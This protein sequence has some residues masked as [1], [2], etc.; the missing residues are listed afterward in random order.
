M[1]GLRRYLDQLYHGATPQA[2]MQTALPGLVNNIK[3]M[4]SISRFYS[5]SGFLGL[6]FTKITNQLVLACKEY[7]QQVTINDEGVDNLWSIVSEEIG[8]GTDSLSAASDT[9]YKQMKTHLENKL[10]G[11]TTQHGHNRDQAPVLVEETTLF[12]RMKACLALL[13][14]Y[15]ECVHNVRDSLGVG[16][17]TMSHYPSMSSVAADSPVKGTVGADGRKVISRTAG[18]YSPSKKSSS[19]TGDS[20]GVTMSDDDAIIGHFE[21]FSARLKQIMD[22]MNTMS[23]Y[24]KLVV[25]SNGI[26]RPRPED[27]EE[28]ETDEIDYRKL[29]AQKN[30]AAEKQQPVQPIPSYQPGGGLNAIQEDMELEEQETQNKKD[31]EKETSQKY[32][33]LPLQFFTEPKALSEEDVEILRMFALMSICYLLNM[34]YCFPEEDVHCRMQYLLSVCYLIC[35]ESSNGSNDRSV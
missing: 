20:H 23:Q 24:Q 34:F 18:G 25:T 35:L 30:K 22:V 21:S 9:L 12:G 19:L 3:Q 6:F 7:M 11:K 15:K 29:H 14:Y 33:S 28:E 27:F 31:E 2:I 13:S 17:H 4:D 10:K 1:E 8:S 16:A 5:R 32:T 26:P